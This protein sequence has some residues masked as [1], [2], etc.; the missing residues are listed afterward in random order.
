VNIVLF[1]HPVFLNS[2][3]MPRFAQMIADGMRKRGHKLKIWSPQPIFF[4]IPV[5][6]KIRK[7]LGYVDQYMLFPLV[8]R[9]RLLAEPADT[10]Y[11]F[12]DQALGPWVPLVK[13]LPHV[14][15]VH[16]FMALRSALGEIPENPTSWTGKQYQAMIRRGF[17]AAKN[18][19][20]VS[21]N[22]KSELSRF[23]PNTRVRSE[24]VY[25]GMNFPFRRMGAAQAVDALQHAGIEA[26]PRGWLLHVGGNQ[27][28]KNRLGVLEIYVAYSQKVSDPLPLLMIGEPPTAAM[29]A[30]LA[31]VSAT[32]SVKFVTGV[33]NQVVCAAYSH[34]RLLIFPSLAEGFGWPI[35]EAM[36]C[37]CPVLTTGEAPMTEVGGSSACY[38]PKRPFE[39]ADVWA[40]HGALQVI[41]VL[42]STSTDAAARMAQGY[43]HVQQFEVQLALRRYE[44]TYQQVLSEAQV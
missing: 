15:H 32:G 31:Q 43:Q 3:S 2:S 9:F 19:I 25:N 13:H 33:D 34:A 37:G 20:S 5:N 6:A 44:A 1:S 11:V 10:V 38:L 22:T 39:N 4:R 30:M 8:V 16:D 36:A 24:V 41:Q 40:K 27:W 21:E 35:A 29:S 12:A 17:S 18:F 23:L 42:D 14:V 28:Y 26:Q 7:W